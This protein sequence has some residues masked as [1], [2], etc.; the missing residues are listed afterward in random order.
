MYRE[1]TTIVTKTASQRTHELT[2]NDDVFCRFRHNDE[3][4][5]APRVLVRDHRHQ[6]HTSDAVPGGR[7]PAAV[8]QV[9]QEPTEGRHRPFGC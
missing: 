9:A 3:I 5:D 2:S 8:Q 1:E 6:G 4:S 7:P